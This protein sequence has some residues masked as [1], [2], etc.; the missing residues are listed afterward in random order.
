MD[1]RTDDK[2]AGQCPFGHGA[3]S[4]GNRDWWPSQLDVQ[5]LNQHAPRSNPMGAAFDYAKEF[6]SLD[7]DA[8]IKDLHTLMTDSQEW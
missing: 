3:K 7:L 6:K 4:R 5:R 1:T 2:S 8:L